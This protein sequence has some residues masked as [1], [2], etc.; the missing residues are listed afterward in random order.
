MKT[1]ATKPLDTDVNGNKLVQCLLCRT[2]GK[3]LFFHQLP[4][5]L[6]SAHNATIAG[7]EESFPGAP[8]ISDFTKE[9]L[10]KARNARMPVA[11]VEKVTPVPEK[12]HFGV[13]TL[14]VRSD[15]TGIDQEYV[16]A[17]DEN[18]QLDD[19]KLEL[20]ALAVQQADNVLAVGPTGCGKT[21]LY[22]ELAS[23][24][25]QPARRINFHGDVRS[26]D[27]LG[28][29]VVEID[30]KTSQAIV[31]WRNGML[32]DAMER[33]HWLILDEIDACPP[34][35]AFAL[36]SVLE[37]GNLTLSADNGRIVK[38]HP[39]FRIL[40]TANTLGKGDD[41]GMYTGTNVMNEAFL[42]RF[43]TVIQF[44]YP[45]PDAEASILVDKTKLDRVTADKFVTVAGFVRA[46][47]EKEECYCTFSTRRLIRW[48]EKTVALRNGAPT[49]KHGLAAEI[50]I[51]N[52]LSKDDRKF[53]EAIVQRVMGK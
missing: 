13:A 27:I 40:A 38:R 23:I 45:R 24:I 43:G 12:L 5:H 39:N 9:Q 18:Y 1:M 29:K 2:Q 26:A 7:Y 41:T 21:S 6:K 4:H 25:G 10:K 14:L 19:A 3:D 17:H 49:G 34:A 28:E 52:K 44:N 50:S 16:P 30:E 32:P 46:A 36:Q 53:V 33:G 20:L 22:M 48:S 51:F 11:A 47:F 37:G 42:D 8:V 31:V 35:V 15:L